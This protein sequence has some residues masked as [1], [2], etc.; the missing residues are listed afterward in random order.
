MNVV[1][2]TLLQALRL[3]FAAKGYRALFAGAF[4]GM[5][6]LFVLIPVWTVAGNTLATEFELLTASNIAIILFISLLYALFA[7]MQ[8][9]AMRQ[10]RTARDVGTVAGG[11]AGALFAGIAGSAFCASCLAPLFAFFGIGFGG[12]LFVLEYRFY[13]VA[14]IALFMLVAL[15]FT[16]R[17]IQNTCEACA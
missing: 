13:I 1:A 2:A 7:T 5:V 12:V 3:T 15:Y 11:G 14:V 17:K 4:V 10:R 16:A 9:Y 8:V 6:A